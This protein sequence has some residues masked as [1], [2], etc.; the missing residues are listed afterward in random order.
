MDV[1]PDKSV[2]TNLSYHGSRSIVG[3]VTHVKK[4][5]LYVENKYFFSLGYVIESMVYM[6][7]YIMINILVIF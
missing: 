6:S 7:K 5:T 2:T 1:A 3:R 4:N